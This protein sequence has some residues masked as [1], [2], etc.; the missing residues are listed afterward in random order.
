MFTNTTTTNRI[1]NGKKNDLTKELY[2]YNHLQYSI[3]KSAMQA[4]QKIHTLQSYD[5]HEQTFC[6]RN[7]PCILNDK[8][9]IHQN[10]LVIYGISRSSH[11]IDYL[12]YPNTYWYICISTHHSMLRRETDPNHCVLS[13]KRFYSLIA[14]Q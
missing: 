13:R 2:S 5:L 9:L 6:N 11:P 1:T 8:R 14:C 10:T 4:E 7:G 12:R 3:L